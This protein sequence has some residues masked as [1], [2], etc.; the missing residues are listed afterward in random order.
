MKK[1]NKG[2][3]C[4]VGIHSLE[5]RKK[6]PAFL[7]D[8]RFDLRICCVMKKTNTAKEEMF[9]VY[10]RKQRCHLHK[11]RAKLGLESS[12]NSGLFYLIVI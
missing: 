8:N 9:S 12:E 2:C 5:I 1:S 3:S 6:R 4:S 7:P 11:I 10:V